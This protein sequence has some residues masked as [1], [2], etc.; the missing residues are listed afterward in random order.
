HVV[1]VARAVVRD[2]DREA[3]ELTGVH[4]LTVSVGHLLHVDPGAV[5][6]DRGGRGV[7]ALVVC[8]LVGGTDRRGVLHGPAVRGV[9]DAGDV[10]LL[11]G[12]RVELRPRA[13]ED[14]LGDVARRR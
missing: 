6:L 8:G 11:G 12:T 10:D 14:P 5:D 13:G 1:G 2:R 3:D 4:G 9:G 7:V